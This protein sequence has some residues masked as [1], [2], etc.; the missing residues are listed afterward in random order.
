MENIKEIL[1]KI[2]SSAL[3]ASKP[4]GNFNYIP[5]KP[6][7][8]TIILGAG[9]AS[10]SMAKAFEKIYPHKLEGLVVTRYGH[11]DKTKFVNV[12]EASHPIPD[13]NGLNATKK[14]IKLAESASKNDLVIFL[15]SGGAS[16]LLFSPLKGVSIKQKQYINDMLL[17]SGAPI[18]EM[19]IVRQSISAI[20]GGRLSEI[21][22]PAKLITYAISDIPGDD[23]KFIGS[24]PTVNSNITNNKAIEILKKY[25]IDV[26]FDILNII[27]NNQLPKVENTPFHYISTPMMALKAAKDEASRNKLTP[28]ILTD[29][30]EGEASKEGERMA[31]LAIK[32]KKERKFKNILLDNPIVLLSGGET[33]VTLKGTGY[34]GRNTEFMLSMAKKLNG[35][36]G[37]YGLAIDT[38]G[39]DGNMDNA[40][41]FISPKTILKANERKLNLDNF[42]QRN[43]SY[44]FF[45][46]INDLII[47]KP[48]LTNVNDFRVILILPS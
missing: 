41:S 16:A 38:D 21:I 6:K 3:N 46:K 47:T 13:I 22:K 11:N 36:E 15:I 29:R 20:K 18:T 33:T 23:P 10:A 25:N 35:I 32:V 28:I 40:G 45:K 12:L 42:L 26:S 24:G 43:D 7:G 9:K 1:F 19:N 44:T 48:T 8:K 14:I 2:M 17:K 27:K 37:I 39:I 34:G 30:L 5:S 31:D 4:D